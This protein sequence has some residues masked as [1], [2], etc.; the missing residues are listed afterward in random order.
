MR[1]T[2]TNATIQ[3]VQAI[4][5]TNIKEAPSIQIIFAELTEAQANQL[6]S[7]GCIVT[8]VNTTKTLIS[9]PPILVAQ[10]LYTPGNIITI[11]KFDEIRNLFTPPLLGQGINVAILGTGI[12]ETHEQVNG[13]IVYRKNFTSDTMHDSF[14]HDTGVCSILVSLAPECS[15]LNFKVIDSAG[16]GTTEDC[17]MAIDECITLFDSKSPIAP[18]LINLS[19]GTEDTEPD[20]PLRVA[21]RA[22]IQRGIWVIAAAGNGANPGTIMSP[23]AE[24]NV[25]AVG[26]A[27]IVSM[28]NGKY[29]F[30]VSD[31]SSRGP[32]K[33]GLVKPDAIFFGEDIKM[34]SSSSDTATVAKSGTSFATP[35]CT[36]MGALVQQGTLLALPNWEELAEQYL[37]N[38][39]PSEFISGLP[40]M[41]QLID[42]FLKYITI[43]PQGIG[44][45]TNDYGEGLPFGD[46]VAQAI[47]TKTAEAGID[48]SS[49]MPAM[50]MMMSIA[51]IV[52]AIG[53]PIPEQTKRVE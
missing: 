29:G 52:K 48:I 28:Y 44:A 1:Y 15:V 13:R 12:R 39:P 26:S 49:I 10:P 14:D 34:A 11:S 41:E 22:A 21:C 5:A 37:A 19:L 45:K 25:F 30:K 3:Q 24:K 43:N 16:N 42:K 23:A 47:S 17:I 9:P 38:V 20:D 2:I 8:E 18:S 35:F 31:F 40:T 36:G 4:G 6:R 51:M 33:E 50:I 32:T 46:L 27:S 53:K 7:Q